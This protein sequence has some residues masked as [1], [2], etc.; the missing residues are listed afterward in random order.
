MMASTP[1][2]RPSMR[3]MRWNGYGGTSSMYDRWYPGLSHHEEVSASTGRA[4]HQSNISRPGCV[5]D[6]HCQLLNKSYSFMLKAIDAALS[7]FG[8]KALALL[9]G[10][11]MLKQC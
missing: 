4:Q 1:V 2:S 10:A 8:A 6:K 3:L 9:W 7:R 5:G 11:S